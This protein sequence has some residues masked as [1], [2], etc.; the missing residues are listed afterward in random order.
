MDSPVIRPFTPEDAPWV[1]DRHAALYARDEGFDDSFGQLVATILDDLL[2]S[3][4]PGWQGWIA[5]GPDGRLGSIFVVPETPGVAKLRLVLL[6]P[7]ARGTEL[8]QRMLDRAFDF[9]RAQGFKQMQLWTHESH[10]AA[11]RFYAR[12]GFRLLASEA[13]RSFGIDVVAQ[14]L[15]RDL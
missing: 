15:E 12:N 1:V 7:E 8:A 4:E 10:V 3:P 9:A 11:G 5:D 13:R 2:S 6:E 14:I